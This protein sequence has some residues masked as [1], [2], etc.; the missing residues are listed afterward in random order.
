MS[1]KFSNKLTVLL[2]S[3]D[4]F[5]KDQILDILHE[6]EYPVVVVDSCYKALKYSLENN[7]DCIV[8]DPDLKEMNGAET[9]KLIKHFRPKTPLITVS[10]EQSY[11]TGVQI[12]EMGV[13]FRLGKP[14]NKA[15]AKELVKTVQKKKIS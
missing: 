3:Q 10:D 14:V 1:A 4:I 12:A 2:A 9:A 7:F 11:A 5:F 13:Y 15:I 8:F 6:Q